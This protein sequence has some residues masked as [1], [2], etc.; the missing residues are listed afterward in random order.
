VK[1]FESM[2]RKLSE[3]VEELERKLDEHKKRLNYVLNKL[4][5]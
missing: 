3:D 4:K 1:E 5:K 2:F